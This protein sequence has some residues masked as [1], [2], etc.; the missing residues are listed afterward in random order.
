MSTSWQHCI[1]P[2]DKG[3]LGIIDP[4]THGVCLTSKWVIRALEGDAP[5]KGLIRFHIQTTCV[6][7]SLVTI[8]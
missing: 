8:S 4:Y 1:Q 7:I 5:W 3:G 6:G 2:K